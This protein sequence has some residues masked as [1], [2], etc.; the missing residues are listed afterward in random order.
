VLPWTIKITLS[1]AFKKTSIRNYEKSNM[2]K[3]CIN[4]S[5]ALNG[6]EG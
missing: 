3:R 2:P 6:R 1:A 5:A 4:E